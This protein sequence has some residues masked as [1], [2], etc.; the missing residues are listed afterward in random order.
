M[1][2]YVCHYKPLLK[3]NIYIKEMMEKMNLKFEFI[4]DFDKEEI[5]EYLNQYK[6]NKTQWN[7]QIRKIKSIL[8][9]NIFSKRDKKISDISKIFLK[10][11]LY[12]INA[13]PE[14][15]P[16]KLSPAEISNSLKHLYALKEI[17]KL[18]CPAL[19]LED[20][21]IAKGNTLK[22]IGEA[23][24]LCTKTFDYVD[25][26]G[27]CNL[28]PSKDEYPINNFKNFSLL[29]TPRSRT[30]S[31]Y[32]ISPKAAAILSKEMIPLIMPTD[33]QFNYLF[34]KHNFKVAWSNPPAFIHGSQSKY[35][36]ST[37]N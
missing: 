1:K 27:G 9:K 12:K 32:I 26:G 36:S 31:G 29:S 20:D 22:L 28:S 19:V 30:T 6:I 34:Q 4:T 11:F 10:T 13:A 35:Y 16:R 2:I 18:S 7:K 8:L 24:E 25:L 21:V 33:W 17:K 14:L 3:R 23:F 37:V 15:K 5:K